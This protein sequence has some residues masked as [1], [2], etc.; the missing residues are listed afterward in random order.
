MRRFTCKCPLR[1]TLY[2][3]KEGEIEGILVCSVM[4]GIC[5][6]YFRHPPWQ[7]RGTPKVFALVRELR[8]MLQEDSMA[9]ENILQQFLLGTKRISTMPASMVWK[10]LYFKPR[11]E[12]SC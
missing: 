2:Y 3:C 7:V 11:G 4:L 12:F 8:K 9:L 1:H 6:P 10:L 5:L